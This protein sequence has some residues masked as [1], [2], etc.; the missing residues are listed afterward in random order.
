ML[1]SSSKRKRKR[2]LIKAPPA[3]PRKDAN[4]GDVIINEEKDKKIKEHQV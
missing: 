1:P 4:R 2:F 3:P